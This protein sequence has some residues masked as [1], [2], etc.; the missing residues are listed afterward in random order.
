[1]VDVYFHETHCPEDRAMRKFLWESYFHDA[2]LLRIDYDRPGRGDITLIVRN[3]EDTWR[4]RFHRVK[5]F[6]HVSQAVL[7]LPLSQRILFTG[8]LDS[9][10]LH[11]CRKEAD[12]PLQHLR[13]D[14]SDGLMDVVFQRF[15]IRREGGRVSY[16]PRVTQDVTYDF[17]TGMT[18]LIALLDED[19]ELRDRESLLACDLFRAHQ[20]GDVSAIRRIARALLQLRDIFHWATN[21]AAYML[22]HHGD[23]SDLPALMA[24]C[25]DPECPLHLRQE[26]QDAMERIMEREA[27]AHA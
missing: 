7:D 5:H 9:A 19:P 13:I 14:L 25:T 24:V 16:R 6:D 1:M 22:G 27:A 23:A 2:E 18:R 10:L 17:A 8:F 3:H 12:K 4:L 11:R 26:M 15:T 21:Y 20:A